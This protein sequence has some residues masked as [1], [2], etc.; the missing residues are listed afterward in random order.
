MSPYPPVSKNNPDR[1]TKLYNAKNSHEHSNVEYPA[2][3]VTTQVM[4]LVK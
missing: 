2:T 4:N 3:T 1:Q